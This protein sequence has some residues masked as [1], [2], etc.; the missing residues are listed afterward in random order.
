MYCR[1]CGKEI[2]DD[3]EF[4][5]H[6]GRKVKKVGTGSFHFLYLK[7]KHLVVLALIVSLLCLAFLVVA[8]MIKL[9]GS[10]SKDIP[11]ERQ[12][13]FVSKKSY[14]GFMKLAEL[15]AEEYEDWSNLNNVKIE[16]HE[17]DSDWKERLFI[18]Q[19]FIE[20]FGIDTFKIYNSAARDKML[21]DKR[22]FVFTGTVDERGLPQRGTALFNDGRSYEGP[23]KNMQPDGEGGKMIQ[24]NG[25]V[26]M[27][28]FSEGRYFKGRYTI[29]S[30][31]Y[32]FEGEFKDGHPFNGAW[33]MPNGTLDSEIIKGE[34]NE[35]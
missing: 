3:A 26:Y 34:Q 27:G 13:E 1:Y 7:Q 11:I 6:C 31:G 9:D 4:C 22:M 23:I 32:Y 15:S 19:Q 8:V 16:G 21:L 17:Y 2:T 28:S 35:K 10:S 20:E 18:N 33:Y 30:D 12:V 14:R 25:D 29:A 5:R 24:P